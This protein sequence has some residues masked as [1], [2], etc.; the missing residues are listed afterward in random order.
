MFFSES[1]LGYAPPCSL[2]V[3]P[4]NTEQR[5]ARYLLDQREDLLRGSLLFCDRVGKEWVYTVKIIE[6][7]GTIKLLQ[8]VPS[9]NV[10]YQRSAVHE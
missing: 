10:I 3:C 2:F 1:D 6:E 5:T 4:E 9:N 7:T 8:N